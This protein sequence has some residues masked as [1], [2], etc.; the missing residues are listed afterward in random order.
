MNDNDKAYLIGT[1]INT[2]LFR[3][4]N[5]DVFFLRVICEL[6]EQEVSYYT[7]Q[8]TNIHECRQNIQKW[9]E[10]DD[11][12]SFAYWILNDNRNFISPV[13]IYD[14]SIRILSNDKTAQ[15]SVTQFYK[16]IKNNPISSSTILLAHILILFS[17]KN[18]LKKGKSVYINITEEDL[19]TY[20][21]LE[22]SE[23]LRHY[24]I[25]KEAA[26]CGIDDDKQLSLFQ[27]K[28]RKHN[29]HENYCNNWLYYASFSPIWS[30]RIKKNRAYPDHIKK[31]VVFIDE[32]D[33]DSFEHF[34][35]KYGYEPDEQPKLVQNKSIME[36]E[37]VNDWKWFYEHYRMNGLVTLDEEELEEFN[38]SGICY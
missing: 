27:L 19:K 8:I 25:L 35:E 6:F 12:R 38:N 14:I 22:V 33:Y 9:I 20:E 15:T 31:S 7:P 24:N 13:E 21:T 23:N 30:E 29:I 36:I 10:K 2:L 3:P 18:Q 28:R 5:T 11:Y 34:Y 26:K 1:I 37:K 17:K 4:F 32:T 16:A